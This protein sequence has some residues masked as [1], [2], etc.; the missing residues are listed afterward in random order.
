MEKWKFPDR[1]KNH[2]EFFSDC[3]RAVTASFI[4]IYCHLSFFKGALDAFIIISTY[5]FATENT[6]KTCGLILITLNLIKSIRIIRFRVLLVLTR[7]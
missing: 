2:N 1:V 3:K 7:Y 6:L 4:Q 5:M